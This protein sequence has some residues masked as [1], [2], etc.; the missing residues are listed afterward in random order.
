MRY[1]CERVGLSRS[2]IYN[3]LTMQS[4]YFDPSFPRP[5]KLGASAV[6]W[7]EL[8]VEAWLDEREKG[9]KHGERAGYLNHIQSSDAS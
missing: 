9:G 7:R 6:G 3:K 1:L 5:L 8:D 4:P 2:S